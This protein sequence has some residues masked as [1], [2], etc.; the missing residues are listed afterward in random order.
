MQAG[1]QGGSTPGLSGLQFYNPHELG[2]RKRLLGLQL[3]PSSYRAGECLTLWSQTRTVIALIQI[4]KRVVTYTKVCWIISDF[5]IMRASY[6]EMSPFPH[7]SVLDPQDCYLA[8]LGQQNSGFIFFSLIYSL[9]KDNCF[10][11]RLHFF[12]SL[13][14]MWH[15][16]CFYLWHYS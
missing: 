9:L 8:E 6:F 7:F 1:R 5:H 12:L 3:A 16:S 10:T 2:R 14:D 15:I 4:S 11:I 13:N